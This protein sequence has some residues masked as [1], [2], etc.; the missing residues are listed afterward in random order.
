[1]SGQRAVAA[2]IGL[3]EGGCRAVRRVVGLL[4]L[5]VTAHPG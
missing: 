2:G 5:V 4:P 3:A 1:L